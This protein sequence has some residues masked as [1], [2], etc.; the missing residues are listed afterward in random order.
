MSGKGIEEA[1]KKIHE[2]LKKGST[3]LD[4]FVLK[5]NVLPESIEQFRQL[6][7]LDLG[8]NRLIEFPES[9]GLTSTD[10]P[11]KPLKI[12]GRFSRAII[13]RHL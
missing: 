8:D 5:L 12:E 9:L 3:E 13:I 10:T 1:E 6:T 11:Q 4:L 7:E 2:A